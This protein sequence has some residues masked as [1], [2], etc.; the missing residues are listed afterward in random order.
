MNATT[1]GK[2]VYF[3][4]CNVLLIIQFNLIFEIVMLN[5][6]INLS[7]KNNFREV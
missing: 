5:N 7:K 2:K 6:L 3:E 4:C 1:K